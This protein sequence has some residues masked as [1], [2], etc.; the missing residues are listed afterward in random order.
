MRL[1]D[2]PRTVVVDGKRLK[3]RAKHSELSPEDAHRQMLAQAQE[4]YRQALGAIVLMVNAT[5]L[6][7]AK[8][9]G[10][11]FLR[12]CGACTWERPAGYRHTTHRSNWS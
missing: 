9:T 2:C 11:A 10:R 3:R 8:E 1:E 7:R 6:E 4:V 5:S 12:E